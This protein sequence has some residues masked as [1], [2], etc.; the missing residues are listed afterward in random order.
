MGFIDRVIE[1]EFMVL[2]NYQSPAGSI[3]STDL[4]RS[5]SRYSDLGLQG[6]P[7]G[8]VKSAEGSDWFL[9]QYSPRMDPAVRTYKARDWKSPGHKLLHMP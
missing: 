7:L 9:L 8:L 3:A 2:V 4:G 6:R 5:Y 1:A